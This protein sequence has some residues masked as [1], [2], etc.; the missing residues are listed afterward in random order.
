MSE[1]GAVDAREADEAMDRYA[2]AG[3]PKDF[4]KVVWLLQPR[5][6]GYLRRQLHDQQSAEDLAQVCFLK[7][8]QHRGRFEPGAPVIPYAFAIA[9]RLLIDKIRRD[10]REQARRERISHQDLPRASGPEDGLAGRQAL[11]RLESA[12]RELPVS[13]REAFELTALDGLSLEDAAA[14]MDT[15]A[16]TLK[17]RK[18]YARVALRERLGDDMEGMGDD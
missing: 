7:L 14:V 9:R 11:A 16:S 18:H 1:S 15:T 5:L 12:L 13:Q 10:R 2:R 3:D 8:H 4:A 17:M 6:L